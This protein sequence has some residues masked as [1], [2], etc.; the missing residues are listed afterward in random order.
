[1]SG[2]S[3]TGG[4]IHA[5]VL[6]GVGGL[7]LAYV[8]AWARGPRGRVAEPASF[9]GALT[10]LLLALNGPLHD[11]SDSYLFS[12]HMIQHLLLTLVVP[13]LLLAGTPAR[14]LDALLARLGRAGLATARWVTRP[15]PALA[16]Y[17]VA[18]VAW[19]LPGPYNAA[20]EAHAWHIVE[21][22]TLIAT[23]VLAW[24]PVLSP[25]TLAPRLHPG[26]QILYLFAFGIPMTAVAAMI[27]GAED[28][29]YPLYAAAPRVFALSP[30]DD[31]RLGGLI[32]WVP[33]GL[34]PLVAFS[35]VFFRWAAAEADEEAS[36]A[37][38]P[39]L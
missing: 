19:H 26:A 15:V 8:L 28:V 17:T 16:L 22:L 38:R 11:L 14:M 6:V 25:S 24:W 37:G 32:M 23:A 36:P 33:A 29:L 39:L 5:D 34:I 10:V 35:V 4:E 9:F 27:T 18:L 7:A 20:L 30:L 1:M 2:F 3:W 31:Q 12:A 13:P 21:H